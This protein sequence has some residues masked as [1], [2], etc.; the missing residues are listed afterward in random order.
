MSYPKPSI[1]ASVSPDGTSSPNPVTVT[2]P[3]TVR[4]Q[5][6]QTGYV[7]EAVNLPD[8]L[9]QIDTG[10]SG[11]YGYVD[12]YDAFTSSGTRAAPVVL[13]FNLQITHVE[14]GHSLLHDPEVLNQ[15]PD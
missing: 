10:M 12:V 8:Q 15:Q 2:A 4:Y 5:M 11:K 9:T 13:N 6:N 7:V 1:T 14:S 3:T